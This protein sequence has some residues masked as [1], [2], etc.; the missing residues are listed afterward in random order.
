MSQSNIAVARLFRV[1]VL[2]AA[3]LG[4]GGAMADVPVPTRFGEVLPIQIPEGVTCDA[5]IP[6]VQFLLNGLDTGLRPLGCDPGNNTLVFRFAQRD[7]QGNVDAAWSAILGNPWNT[8]K[9]N[10]VRDF[11]LTLSK[12]DAAGVMQSIYSQ[13]KQLT[14]VRKEWLIVGFFLIALAWIGLTLAGKRSGMLRD[15]NSTASGIDRPY[16]LARVQMAWWFALVISAYVFLWV[17]TDDW[18]PIN[19]SIL[20]LIGISSATGLTAAGIDNTDNRVVRSTD[21]FFLD[22]LTDVNGI[23]LPRLQ[24][25]LW[26]VVLGV[27][28][29]ARVFNDLKMPTFDASTL[30]LLGI[31]AGAYVGFKVP[32]KQS[33]PTDTTSTQEVDKTDP[34]A[35]YTPD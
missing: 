30:G 6:N 35:G 32:E 19:S 17:L 25:L 29:L 26:N 14:I 5:T 1:L 13:T 21:G 27:F 28:F 4:I 23:T 31:S 9:S 7:A 18:A 34:K 15:S 16:S 11:Q 8:S 24:L 33:K 3:S 20:A 22:I 12:P 10:F 2:L